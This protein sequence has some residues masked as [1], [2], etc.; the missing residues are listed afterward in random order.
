MMAENSTKT[1]KPRRGPG[2]PFPKGRSGNPGGRPRDLGELRELARSHSVTAIEVL[3]TIAA[4]AKVSP[5]AR[6]SA[7]SALLDR[8]YGRPQPADDPADNTPPPPMLRIEVVYVEPDG[9]VVNPMGDGEHGRLMSEKSPTVAPR[10]G[11]GPS[12]S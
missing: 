4:D 7:A 5:S 12:S 11:G 3:A 6:V 10:D 9:G 2:R 8:G 1:A